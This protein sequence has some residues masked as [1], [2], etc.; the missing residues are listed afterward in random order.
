MY[1][2]LYTTAFIQLQNGHSPVKGGALHQREKY[3]DPRMQTLTRRPVYKMRVA[4][5]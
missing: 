1:T 4:V 2:S 3:V 5:N